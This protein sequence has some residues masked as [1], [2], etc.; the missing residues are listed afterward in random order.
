M[1]QLGCK[2][3][4]FK[5]FI[6]TGLEIDTVISNGFAKHS[7]QCHFTKHTGAMF[8]YIRFKELIL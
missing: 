3:Q 4:N 8:I 2:E 6:V 5:Y 7:L 1:Q